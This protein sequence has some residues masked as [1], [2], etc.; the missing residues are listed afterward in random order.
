M[1]NQGDRVQI[2]LTQTEALAQ[3][4]LNQ[5][6][7]DIAAAQAV[8][9]QVQVAKLTAKKAAVQGTPVQPAEID[10]G[11]AALK[12]QQVAAEQ[13]LAT[14]E[15]INSALEQQT[16][17]YAE[18]A[19]AQRVAAAR[20]VENIPT[21]G[22]SALV[23][24]QYGQRSREAQAA[25]L[26]D[27]EAADA[28]AAQAAQ[29]ARVTAALAEQQQMRQKA[30]EQLVRQAQLVG[31][32]AAESA[33]P[34][35]GAQ[36]ASIAA[37]PTGA[38]AASI[39][40]P[41]SADEQHL[42][43]SKLALS[44][45]N[46]YAKD[47]SLSNSA[48]AG[49]FTRVGLAENQA[50]NALRAHGALTTEF[51]Q[52]LQRGE[53]TIQEFGYQISATIG[54]FAGWTTAATATYGAL[55]ALVEFGKG[56]IDASNATQ[57]LTRTI[58][59]V[60]ANEATASIRKLSSETNTSVKEAGDAVLQFSRT[61]H[62]V[63]DATAAATLGLRAYKLDNVSLADSVGLSTALTTQ[64]GLSVRQLPSVYDMLTA[65]QRTWNASMTQMVPLITEAMG[66]VHNAGGDLTQFMQIATFAQR[67]L[68]D[69]GGQRIAQIFG[70]SAVQQLDPT[71]TAGKGNVSALNAMGIDTGKGWT[72]TFI[73]ALHRSLTMSPEQLTS[74]VSRMFT[75][76]LGASVAGL[77]T[78]S[79]V[80]TF[81][82]MSKGPQAL[83]PASTQG[84]QAK[85]FAKNEA[86]AR[87]ELER[88]V[89]GLQRMGSMLASTGLL[90]PFKEMLN[91][92]LDVFGVVGKIIEAFDKLSGGW[93]TGL[94]TVIAL[95]VAM[96][97]LSRT[98]FGQSIGGL[99][100]IRSVTSALP[101][102]QAT[103]IQLA[104]Q[105]AI[106]GSRQ[107]VEQIS[108]SII[109]TTATMGEVNARAAELNEQV[110]RLEGE[111][112]GL[113]EGDTRLVA[114]QEERNTA[115][116]QLK[117]LQNE[118]AAL[119]QQRVDQL[120]AQK[121]FST[122][123]VGLQKGTISNEGVAALNAQMGA[124]TAAAEAEAAPIG[125]GAAVQARFGAATTKLRSVLPGFVT[126]T[127]AATAA[128][129]AEAAEVDAAAVVQA[130]AAAK[131]SLS[132]AA[133]NTGAVAMADLKGA[134]GAMSGFF[135]V[136]TIG[137][138]GLPILFSS[139][140]ANEK[141]LSNA[142]KQLNTSLQSGPGTGDLP[143]LLASLNNVAQQK[144]RQAEGYDI[145]IVGPI[146]GPLATGA[147][148]L[149]NKQPGQD[150]F[151]GGPDATKKATAALQYLQTGI[152]ERIAGLATLAKTLGAGGGPALRA[153]MTN[154]QSAIRAGASNYVKDKTITPAEAAT[155]EQWMTNQLR[156]FYQNWQAT[157]ALQPSTSAQNFLSLFKG[158]APKDQQNTIDTMAMQAKVY[159]MTPQI[160]KKMASAYAVMAQQYAGSTDVN[161]T[162]AVDTARSEFIDAVQQDARLLIDEAGNTRNKKQKAALLAAAAGKLNAGTAALKSV[163]QGLAVAVAADQV[164]SNSLNAELQF[165]SALQQQEDVTVSRS[166]L[167]GAE[168]VGGLAKAL[169]ATGA[170]ILSA[171]PAWVGSLDA[172]RKAS[173]AANAA[174]ATA[175]KNLGSLQAS[176][177]TIFS[178]LEQQM[179]GINS[180]ISSATKTPKVASTPA[181]EDP[182]A[183]AKL[184]RQLW[185]AQ[186]AED[187][188]KQAQGDIALAQLEIK[189]AKDIKERLQGEID[190]AKAQD[191]YD[192]A[193]EAVADAEWTLRE[194]QTTD[195]LKKA[196]LAVQAAAAAVAFDAAHGGTGTATALQDRAKLNDARNSAIQA[197]VTQREDTI[198]FQLDMGRISYE[199]AMNEYEGLLK[200]HGITTDLRRQVLEAIQQLKQQSQS[201]FGELALGTIRL[202]TPY[203]IRRAAGMA[204]QGVQITQ[205]YAT[206]IQV[207]DTASA[208]RV[209]VV[210]DNYHR[211]TG[212]AMARATG[213]R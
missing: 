130:E 202:P 126:A 18:M 190:L 87:E 108:A 5:L 72:Q 169:I 66:A 193:V 144:A 7:T 2:Q 161:A 36:R 93:K 23:A 67:T 6:E 4:L 186:N 63:D 15:A 50:S 48:L 99:P 106:T 162:R 51:L 90:A 74:M 45:Y 71:T 77:F 122:Q 147:E 203:E 14:E 173:A 155:L 59:G 21:G 197:S 176:D 195:P 76:R 196:Q 102:F 151:L 110:N 112:Q 89:N 8:G 171:V 39:G 145:P 200:V 42:V 31:Q 136:W 12:E 88:I 55:G 128:S 62:N 140:Q 95:R 207:T 172:L 114:L 68:P 146:V 142:L 119:E 28:A 132:E 22:A 79:A 17:W 104:R 9:D 180:G 123:L 198:K 94:D 165:A 41:L 163:E 170:H 53:T 56:A 100:G 78:P 189:G 177:A 10:A 92:L 47:A 157:K 60:N 204:T 191:E 166:I 209:G 192:K 1:A 69:L 174:L 32:I 58:N 20:N 205:N 210:M 138:I 49:S 84:A 182:Y 152:S 153:E 178:Q 70:R 61:F 181:S 64:F 34:I 150:S 44:E 96:M 159:G 116:A 13:V 24:G 188:V 131:I 33:T 208:N 30:I 156:Q 3:K 37:G 139:W 97:A 65:G 107:V 26:A 16:A 125:L 82:R 127:E 113:E 29:E 133:M 183:V 91:L 149:L 213:R 52:A 164:A 194:S 211:G 83:T 141:Q 75:P 25:A 38:A 158:L 137:L 109:K 184:Q 168:H 148:E 98:Q 175:E 129:T 27:K 11:T 117:I 134:M 212:K 86:A 143:G 85:E 73:N 118:E 101:G 115:K 187:P 121:R 124:G 135:N 105:D 199:T 35:S 185:Q 43:R 40:G 160:L 120:A 206:T 111:M 54:K 57:K 19:Q 103:P 46:T 154:L 179:K 201:Q 167:S 81:D 80:Q